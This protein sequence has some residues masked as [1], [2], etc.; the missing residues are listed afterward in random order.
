ML[1]SGH[2]AIV[3][4]ALKEYLKIYGVCWQK[5]IAKLFGVKTSEIKNLIQ[6]AVTVP[7][8]L[9]EKYKVD[10][11]GR[12][13]LV[14]HQKCMILSRVVSWVILRNRDQEAYDEHAG[15][16]RFLHSMAPSS[17][18]SLLETQR[19]IIDHLLG[20]YCE[21]LTADNYLDRM[22][23]L[24][25]VLHA[26]GDAYAPGHTKRMYPSE[27]KTYIENL[28]KNRLF[29][30]NECVT[31]HQL[32]EEGLAK[33]MY[34]RE[35]EVLSLSILYVME[36]LVH[37]GKVKLTNDK[38][39]TMTRLKEKLWE[40][41][42]F[43][44]KHQ[45]E[46]K[47]VE[48]YISKHLNQLWYVLKERLMFRSMEKNVSKYLNISQLNY[49]SDDERP[50]IVAYQFFDWSAQLWAHNTY[51][52]ISIVKEMGLCKSF[53]HHIADIYSGICN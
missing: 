41:S 53:F 39:S 36:N 31:T 48:D 10:K 6:K 30:S 3:K 26:M 44:K 49:E 18:F 52:K 46:S 12:I 13:E 16:L 45:N 7:D 19:L 27:V 25:C 22:W 47:R 8:S 11:D 51:D 9:C 23:F 50:K 38:D 1:V 29:S 24:G 42:D 20:I 4:E 2:I 35:S 32:T 37:D 33:K 21:A 15:K 28:K 43:K 14:N 5:E 17:N 34:E 40:D